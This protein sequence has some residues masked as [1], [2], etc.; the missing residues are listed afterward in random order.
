[1]IFSKQLNIL[2]NIRDNLR[3]VLFEKIQLPFFSFIDFLKDL[4]KSKEDIK[5]FNKKVSEILERSEKD[6][7]IYKKL[8]ERVREISKEQREIQEYIKAPQKGTLDSSYRNSLNASLL[9]LDEEKINNLQKIL[10][11]GFDPILKVFRKDGYEE[12]LLSNLM[13]GLKNESPVF[14][15]PKLT[16]IQGGQDQVAGVSNTE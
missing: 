7:E 3:D 14:T 9:L 6:H 15:R 5:C 10:D 11:L 16:V 8:I 2:R 4:T 1:M 13:T 12:G